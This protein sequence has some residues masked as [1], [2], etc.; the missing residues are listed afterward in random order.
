MK[1]DFSRVDDNI[2]LESYKSCL[3]KSTAPVSGINHGFM[4]A[5]SDTFTHT[6]QMV[7]YVQMY[8]YSYL[9]FLFYLFY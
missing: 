4:V 8:M 5:E 1:G 2:D 7:K 9:F 6:I 3:L